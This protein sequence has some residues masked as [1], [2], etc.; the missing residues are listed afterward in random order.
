M[1]VNQVD[2]KPTT[3]SL[4]FVN[5]GASNAGVGASDPFS[6]VLDITSRSSGQE[7][8]R[9]DP[10]DS[11]PA[12]S[13]QAEDDSERRISDRERDTDR[14]N[15]SNDDERQ[16]HQVDSTDATDSR[17]SEQTNDDRSVRQTDEGDSTVDPVRNP[18][19]QQSNILTIANKPVILV[20]FPILTTLS[21]AN[22]ITWL[23]PRDI[24]KIREE[25]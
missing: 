15:S 3:S 23:Q 4:A 14:P 21:I 9:S 13:T 24:E 16:T 17:S 12:R 20:E 10:N 1:S 25:T 2:S 22:L 18:A 6:I 8:F 5:R 19:Q 7:N 11:Q